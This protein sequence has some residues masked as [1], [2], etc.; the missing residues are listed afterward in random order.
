M[1][2]QETSPAAEDDGGKHLPAAAAAAAAEGYGSS[3]AS[4]AAVRT[5][6]SAVCNTESLAK[7]PY[8]VTDKPS[9]KSCVGASPD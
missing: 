9:A 1:L 4:G 5:F 3:G 8:I 6:I 7:P 2:L